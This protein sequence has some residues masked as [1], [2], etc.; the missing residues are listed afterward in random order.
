MD[1]SKI[2]Q[3]RGW[4]ATTDWS[5][6]DWTKIYGGGLPAP[7][8]P[9]PFGM[10]PPQMSYSALALQPKTPLFSRPLRHAG[11]ASWQHDSLHTSR[12]QESLCL[13][14]SLWRPLLEVIRD[15]AGLASVKSR[16][17]GWSGHASPE[18]G[19]QRPTCASSDEVMPKQAVAQMRAMPGGPMGTS[20]TS[21]RNQAQDELRGSRRQQR[22]QRALNAK[23]HDKDIA[24][25]VIVA[26]VSPA[27]ICVQET[28]STLKFAA[29][30]KHIR[31]SVVRNEAQRARFLSG[32]LGLQWHNGELEGGGAPAAEATGT[33][34]RHLT[35]TRAGSECV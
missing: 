21:K 32:W 35:A 3:N 18:A 24:V 10:A 1:W 30:A 26:N 5:K 2:F 27:Q 12:G 15:H 20:N 4:G 28:V 29:R 19:F 13:C 22:A 9:P 31:C 8:P 14:Q 33:A 7:A 11:R 6:I 16:R 34:Q 17:V 23:G 25:E